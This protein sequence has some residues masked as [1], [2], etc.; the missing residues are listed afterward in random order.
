MTNNVEARTAWNANAQFW[1]ERMADGN[2]FFRLLV[3]PCVEELLQPR[4]GESL[5]D[6]A[7]GNGLTSAR[8]ADAGARVV[9]IDFSDEMIQLAKQRRAG[10]HVDYRLVDAT[11]ADALAGLGA[12]QFD[13]ALCNMA[14]MDMADVRPLFAALASLLRPDG[15]FVFSVTHPCFNNPSSV[16]LGELEDREGEL[17]ATYSVK[18]SRYLTPFTQQ[19]VAMSGQPM[20]HPYFHRPLTVLLGEGFRAG[21]VLDGFLERSFPPDEVG[22]STPLSWS[23][24]FSDIPPV[25]IARMRKA[26]DNPR[27]RRESV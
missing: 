27:E 6:V 10:G 21:F 16:Q 24:R 9:A 18:V 11:D 3:W 14:L 12:S 19:G 1:H 4:A 26:S 8:L 23:G 25:L 15:R 17:V 13:G 22:G 20:P 5:L 2:D 7:C